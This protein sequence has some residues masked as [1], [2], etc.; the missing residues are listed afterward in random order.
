M[1]IA[2]NTQTG[3]NLVSSQSGLSTAIEI[4]LDPLIVVGCLF[5]AA[6]VF[7]QSITAR[8]IILAVIALSMTFP[9]S[10]RLAD[11]PGRM[12]RKAAMDWMIVALMLI[13]FGYVT[14]YIRYFPSSFVV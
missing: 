1:Q 14:G 12:V 8:H 9:G 13:L 11:G 2:V 3:D 4:F 10:L 6:A 7:D 5:A